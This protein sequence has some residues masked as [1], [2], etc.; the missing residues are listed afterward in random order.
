LLDRFGID[1]KPLADGRPLTADETNVLLRVLYRW[2]GAR[3]PGAEPY[4]FNTF[5]PL[6]AEKAARHDASRLDFSNE[7][8]R[9]RGEFFAL[10]GKV[11]AVEP[12]AVPRELVARF[13]FAEYYR[14]RLLLDGD[15]PMV[16]YVREVPQAWRRGARPGQPGGALAVYLKTAPGDGPLWAARRIAWYPDTPLGRLGMDAGLLDDLQDRKPLRPAE[17]EA[18]YQML[19]AVY[20]APPGELLRLADAQLKAAGQTSTSVVPLFNAPH[21]ARGQLVGLTGTAR[22]AIKI[23][24]DDPEIVARLGIDHYY[25]IGLFTGDSQDNPLVIC[26]PELPPGMPPGEDFRYLEEIRVAGFF[27]KVWAY[28]SARQEEGKPVAQLAPLVIAQTPVWLAP[29]P[30]G[31]SPLTGAVSVGLALGGLLLAA[32]M[33]WQTKAI[34]SRRIQR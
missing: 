6:D 31:R 22:R 9:V 27:L 3:A 4:Q 26:T 30:R 24:I 34:H 8:Q 10:R 16:V 25:E 29:A 14:C 1:L 15:R 2:G 33:L 32:W 19:A 17:Q 20:R 7:S 11:V 5:S 13:D 21:T 23:Y 12:V 18:F 28:R